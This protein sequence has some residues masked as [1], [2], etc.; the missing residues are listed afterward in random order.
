MSEDTLQ[1]NSATEPADLVEALWS[2]RGETPDLQ[3]L[4]AEH[5]AWSARELR[6]ALLLDQ[7]FRWRTPQPWPTEEYLAL[8]PQRAE[9]DG[10][11]L[12]LICGECRGRSR[13][14]NPASFDE[15]VRRFPHL[16]TQLERQLEIASWFEDAGACGRPRGNVDSLRKRHQRVVA[17]VADR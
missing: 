9:D 10:L 3:R 7:Q 6:D 2:S 15:L 11:T 13:R 12:D 8:I 16:Q 17:R 14:G 1:D 5:P 4:L